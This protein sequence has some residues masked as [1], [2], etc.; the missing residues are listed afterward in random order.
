MTV[1]GTNL[2]YVD[3]EEEI[4]EVTSASE[5]AWNFSEVLRSLLPEE[6]VWVYEDPAILNSIRRG[7][8]ESARGEGE[9]ISF[10]QY[11]TEE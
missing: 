10:A 11:A 3:D 2:A 4:E 5:N 8:E 9:V 1:A 6:E 7:L